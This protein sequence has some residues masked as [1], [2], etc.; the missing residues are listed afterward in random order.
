MSD[1]FDLV[2]PLKRA[3]AVPGEFTGS[4]ANT[5]DTDLADVLLDA[6][7]EA[8]LFGFFGAHGSDDD[9]IVT[10][11]LSRGEGAL[12]VIFAMCRVLNSEIRNRKTHVKYEAKGAIFE[13][14]QSATMLV[15]LLKDYQAQ[16]ADL[17]KRATYAAGSA[18]YMADQ[19]F[20]RAVG[21]GSYGGDHPN[22]ASS[23]GPYN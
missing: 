5:T 21:Y 8:Q 17:L 1:L 20:L 18:F 13:Q 22:Y 14:D 6:F 4:F 2:D 3:V 7:A 12:V 10:P 9:G 15:Q 19:Y 16:K 11:D 23:Y